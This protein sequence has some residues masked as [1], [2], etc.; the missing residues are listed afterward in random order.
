MPYL[1]APLDELG[2]RHLPVGELLHEV[3]VLFSY[4]IWFSYFLPTY[5]YI[6]CLYFCLCVCV[7]VIVFVCLSFILLPPQ[8]R[9]AC[10]PA[11]QPTLC[12][13][14]SFLK[15]KSFSVIKNIIS[16]KKSFL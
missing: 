8:G 13:V 4:L 7:C 15:K 14:P 9:Q 2:L 10:A 3:R 11:G 5:L 1:D 16:A 6:V 12:P